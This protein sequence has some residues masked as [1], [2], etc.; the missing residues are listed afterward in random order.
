MQPNKSEAVEVTPEDRALF[1]RL[2]HADD[3]QCE[4]IDNGLAFTAEIE[5]IA[6]HRIARHPMTDKIDKAD[7]L[8]DRIEQADAGEQRAL[9]ALCPFCDGSARAGYEGDDDGG[10][11][12]V[13]CANHSVGDGHFAGVHADTEAEAIAAWNA[14]APDPRLARAVEALREIADAREAMHREAEERGYTLSP[15]SA[16]SPARLEGIARQALTDLST[17][18]GE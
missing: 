18:Q 10:Y 1:K 16:V 2:T 8:A 5:D 4:R 17:I 13:E 11:A 6:R 12:Y 14:R 3:E 9:L 7:A 15:F